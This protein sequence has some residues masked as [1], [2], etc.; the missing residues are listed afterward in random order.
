[1]SARA[2]V[3]HFKDE[4]EEIVLKNGSTAKNGDD[5]NRI[6]REYKI[7]MFEWNLMAAAV[8]NASNAEVTK[9]G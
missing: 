7:K 4:F 2:A 8:Y 5:Y 3:E 6:S 9:I 1:M